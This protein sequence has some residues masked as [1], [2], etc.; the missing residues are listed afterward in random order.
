MGATYP[1]GVEAPATTDEAEGWITAV[2]GL[3]ELG[4]RVPWLR[5]KWQQEPVPRLARALDRLA[6]RGQFAEPRA[7]ETMVAVALALV[8]ERE[9]PLVV[10]LRQQAKVGAHLNLDRL[11]RDSLTEVSP[12]ES[13]SRTPA[14]RKGRE[15]TLGERRSLARKPSRIDLQ[16]LL[17]DP[18]P[19]VLRQLLS[20]S[21]LTES[22]VMR[23]ATLRPAR[24]VALD[25]L[26]QSF[27]WMAR[28]RVRLS[29]ILNPGCPHGI[30]L[31]LISICPRDDL[32]L[33]V[34]STTISPS[35][36]GVAVELMEKLPPLAR[37]SDSAL[38]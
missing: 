37:S 13:Q 14:Y 36:R 1:K 30:A 35:L 33:I 15:L 25:E 31:P 21:K 34:S 38:Q 27:R 16:K 20:S 5:E 10:A 9:S 32:E 17:F 28:R 11:V 12:A 23:I 2:L 7:R 19:L 29:L 8:H 26:V 18:D 24:L 4:F 22:D 6:E 3:P